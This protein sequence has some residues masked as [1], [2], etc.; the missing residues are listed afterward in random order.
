M[1]LNEDTHRDSLSP[2]LV[3]P[4]TPFPGIKCMKSIYVKKLD[5][6][7]SKLIFGSQIY[8]QRMNSLKQPDCQRLWPSVSIQD[9]MKHKVSNIVVLKS[10]FFLTKFIAFA[11]KACKTKQ[12]KIKKIFCCNFTLKTANLC[13]HTVWHR[14]WRLPLKCISSLLPIKRL[15]H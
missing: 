3:R 14:V 15:G 7:Q 13:H 5:K 8:G 2:P 10:L 1:V 9:I 6:I 4:H 12:I 11:I